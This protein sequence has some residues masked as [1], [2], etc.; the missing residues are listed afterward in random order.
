MCKLLDEETRGTNTYVYVHIV[1]V[2]IVC[3]AID[4][5]QYLIMAIK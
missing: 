4:L 1:L 2:I 3:M 5:C